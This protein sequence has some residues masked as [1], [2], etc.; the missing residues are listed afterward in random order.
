MPG[1]VRLWA[2]D[3]ADDTRMVCTAILCND[4]GVGQEHP[5]VSAQFV[6]NFSSEL[7]PPDLSRAPLVL[8]SLSYLRVYCLPITL[9]ELH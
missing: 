2:G 3:R 8:L 6:R 4:N 7:L 9:A 1:R 5:K